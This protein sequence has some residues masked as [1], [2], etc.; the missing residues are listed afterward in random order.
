MLK[1]KKELGVIEVI[2]QDVNKILVDKD[3]V[4]EDRFTKNCSL[5]FE[6]LS[7]KDK[8]FYIGVDVLIRAE[9]EQKYKVII[10]PIY[11][12]NRLK[13]PLYYYKPPLSIFTSVENSKVLS[14]FKDLQFYKPI[15]LDKEIYQWNSKEDLSVIA[16]FYMIQSNYKKPIKNIELIQCT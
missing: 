11:L 9:P 13:H 8:V 5:I 15:C 10:Y 3:V 6:C 14:S 4:V 7:S 2:V 1:I 16:L 12:K